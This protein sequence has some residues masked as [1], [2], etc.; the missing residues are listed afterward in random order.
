MRRP[1][2]YCTYVR[3]E[4]TAQSFHTQNAKTLRLS[5]DISVFKLREVMIGFLPRFQTPNLRRTIFSEGLHPYIENYSR[6]FSK[7]TWNY[8][9]KLED[10]LWNLGKI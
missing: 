3:S 9:R 7:I 5:N 4:S 2:T 1:G 6:I 8:G 10:G